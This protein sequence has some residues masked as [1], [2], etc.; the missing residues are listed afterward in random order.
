M[1]QKLTAKDIIAFLP[2]QLDKANLYKQLFTYGPALVSGFGVSEEFKDTDHWYHT[3]NQTDKFLGMHAML[4]VGYRKFKKNDGAENTHYLLQN[5]WKSK[6]Y[7]EVDI[8]FLI[9][10]KAT[11]RFITKEQREMGDFPVNQNVLVECDVDACEQ[12][13]LEG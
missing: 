13:I 3:G 10:S 5:W 8:D 6:S 4:L 2:S 9:S 12:Y 7:V 1:F 11:V